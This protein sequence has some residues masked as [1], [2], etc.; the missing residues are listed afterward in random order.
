MQAAD[1]YRHNLRATSPPL[2]EI[3]TSKEFCRHLPAEGRQQFAAVLRDLWKC[4]EPSKTPFQI[5]AEIL[6]NHSAAFFSGVPVDIKSLHTHYLGP[7]VVVGEKETTLNYAREIVS[8]IR[9]TGFTPVNFKN[10]ASAVAFTDDPPHLYEPL[11][12]SFC[13]VELNK[14]ETAI[15]SLCT[16]RDDCPLREPLRQSKGFLHDDKL[17]MLVDPDKCRVFLLLG[18]CNALGDA[19][20]NLIATR[21]H[22]KAR[23]LEIESEFKLEYDA[24]RGMQKPDEFIEALR[25][26]GIP[27]SDAH[28]MH[29]MK[30][31]RG[32]VDAA[33]DLLLS[34]QLNETIPLTRSESDKIHR[35]ISGL[36]RDNLQ[37]MEKCFHEK[38]NCL[39]GLLERI[40]VIESLVLLV[41]EQCAVVR[42]FSDFDCF[43]FS[44]CELAF[45]VFYTLLQHRKRQSMM[46]F[47]CNDTLLCFLSAQVETPNPKAG[48]AGLALLVQLFAYSHPGDQLGKCRPIFDSQTKLETLITHELYGKVQ[49][50]GTIV[51]RRIFDLIFG[52]IDDMSSHEQKGDITEKIFFDALCALVNILRSYR[53]CFENSVNP[54]PYINAHPCCSNCELNRLTSELFCKLQSLGRKKVVKMLQWRENIGALMSSLVSDWSFCR[55]QR[56]ALCACS[57]DN[58][59][60]QNVFQSVKKIVAYLKLDDVFNTNPE[61]KRIFSALPPCSFTSSPSGS[62]F[63]KPTAKILIKVPADECPSPHEL[64]TALSPQANSAVKEVPYRWSHKHISP[65]QSERMTET[66]KA[67]RRCQD[68]LGKMRSLQ[69]GRGNAGGDDQ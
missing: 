37:A 40:D 60:A 62:P 12:W 27:G 55:A 39:S 36:V 52:I 50:S 38:N 54:N 32:N 9:S 3:V 20:K 26:L 48:L 6:D 16:T 21:E 46:F 22:L 33:A 64:L 66:T 45:L 10:A 24:A 59:V 7:H 4:H 15:R 67:S 43:N 69:C 2:E 49:Q 47:S 8:C 17:L 5:V 19:V 1:I 35:E 13:E 14:I 58:D 68:V 18:L 34:G 57:C 25:S 29:A 11:A 51:L 41:M 56:P 53:W 23:R 42:L 31:C 30:Q 65:P 63:L 28:I 61:L 44:R